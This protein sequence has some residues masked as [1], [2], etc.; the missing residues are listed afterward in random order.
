MTCAWKE[1][2]F[3]KRLFVEG[4]YK[5]ALSVVVSIFVCIM[6]SYS[7]QRRCKCKFERLDSGSSL[8]LPNYFENLVAGIV[9]T[10]LNKLGTF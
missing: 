4:K 8:S 10:I 3:F 9:S 1:L 2:H 5:I 6:L 7:V